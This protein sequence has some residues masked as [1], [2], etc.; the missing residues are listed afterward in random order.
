[1]PIIAGPVGTLL[2]ALAALIA[3]LFWQSIPGNSHLIVGLIAFALLIVTS[4]S[5]PK[6]SAPAAD[7]QA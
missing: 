5:L 7:Q 2:I 3:L 6:Q 4:R 1:M